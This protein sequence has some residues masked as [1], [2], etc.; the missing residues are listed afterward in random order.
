MALNLVIN[1]SAMPN[2]STSSRCDGDER[3]DGSTATERSCG[4]AAVA[5]SGERVARNSSGTTTA[6]ARRAATIQSA[7]LRRAPR[8][9][10]CRPTTGSPCGRRPQLFGTSVIVS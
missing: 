7:E 1:V 9:P 6:T 4:S 2:C 10:G 5:D 8:T 3:P